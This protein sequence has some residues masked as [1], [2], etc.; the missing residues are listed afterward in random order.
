MLISQT[1][2]YKNWPFTKVPSKMGTVGCLHSYWEVSCR[3]SSVFSFFV[4]PWVSR[5]PESS[6]TR[7]IVRHPSRNLLQVCEVSWTGTWPLYNFRCLLSRTGIEKKRAYKWGILWIK[8]GTTYR[9]N[10]F[11]KEFG[12]CKRWVKIQAPWHW[13]INSHLIKYFV[14]LKKEK[15]L[16][17]EGVPGSKKDYKL[18]FHPSKVSNGSEDLYHPNF[19]F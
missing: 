14:G 9:G 15:K 19:F 4:R 13:D 12:I 10:C 16:R 5:E 1:F 7:P 2:L 11:Y 8:F 6:L 3:P 17:F 18:L